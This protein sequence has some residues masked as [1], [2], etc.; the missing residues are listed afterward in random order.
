MGYI[1]TMV[2]SVGDGSIFIYPF[3]FRFLPHSIAV[4][5]HLTSSRLPLRSLPLP[6]L[7]SFV[8]FSL[9][10]PLTPSYFFSLFVLIIPVRAE[11]I[12][13]D[14]FTTFIFFPLFIFYKKNICKSIYLTYSISRY[15]NDVVVTE[16][17]GRPETIH[18]TFAC[19]TSSKGVLKRKRFMKNEK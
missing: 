6:L 11:I 12:I 19:P 17:R 10:I 18:P 9:S 4:L 1:I 8:P 3:V 2:T 7:L 5:F 15:L 14:V 13:G 16:A